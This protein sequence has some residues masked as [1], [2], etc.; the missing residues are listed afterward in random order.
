VAV[1]PGGRHRRLT[2]ERGRRVTRTNGP[3]SPRGWW[4]QDD[5]DRATD[6]RLRAAQ[7]R[8]EALLDQRHSALVLGSHPELADLTAQEITRMPM[9]EFARMRERAGLVNP[10]LH[11]VADNPIPAGPSVSADAEIRAQYPNSPD[12]GAMG[13]S[14]YAAIRAQYIRPASG[15]GRGLFN[16]AE[17]F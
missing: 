17:R 7:E 15:T 13:L 16:Q 4:T 8:Y 3:Y 10:D 11:E 2:A 14:E 1:L 6:S 12:F 9:G 5:A